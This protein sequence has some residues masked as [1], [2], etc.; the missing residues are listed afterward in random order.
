MSLHPVSQVKAMTNSIFQ[1]SNRCL[2]KIIYLINLALRTGHWFENYS[3]LEHLWILN[4]RFTHH[5]YFVLLWILHLTIYIVLKFLILH[6]VKDFIKLCFFR[7]Y[8][9]IYWAVCF[10]QIF[11]NISLFFLVFFLHLMSLN[12][13]RISID[14]FWSF[15][16]IRRL[17]EII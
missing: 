3:I 7:I 4:Y 9:W 10:F 1:Q 17:I 2:W 6:L 12:W 14:G 8:C 11:L 5:Y 16:K 13:R 15:F